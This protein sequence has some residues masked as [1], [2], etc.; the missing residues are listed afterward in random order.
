VFIAILF[1]GVIRKI[2]V[3]IRQKVSSYSIVSVVQKSFVG[4]R[5]ENK[6]NLKIR[7]LKKKASGIWFMTWD[8]V[9]FL[10]DEVKQFRAND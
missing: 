2:G 4:F 3:R 10:R 9:I 5:K 7:F 6:H 1:A 8:G